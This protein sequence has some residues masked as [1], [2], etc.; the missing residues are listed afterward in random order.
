MSSQNSRRSFLTL[1]TT[2][3]ALA[4]CR[5]QA[6]LAPERAQPVPA[7]AASATPSEKAAVAADGDALDVSAVEDLMREHGVIRR[8]LVVYRESAIRLRQ[9]P[10]A[11]LAEA[12]QSS[13]KL[14]QTFGEEYHERALEEA[15]LFPAVKRAGGPA[16]NSIDALLAQ[17][18]RGRELTSYVLTVTQ[19]PL[20]V[21][22]AEPLARVLEGF[23]RMYEEHAAH[24]DT[25]VFQAWKK[26]LSGK[27]L[28]EMG[29]LFEDIEHKTFGKDGFEAANA[30]IAGIEASLGITLSGLLAPPP[31]V[32]H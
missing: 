2:G 20:S 16:S 21:A 1:A 10:S 11:L 27:Q 8:I 29:E 18:Q 14:M 9:K 19:R 13:A 17:H 6:Q 22:S 32:A 31:P 15:Q 12:L 28:D 24:E 7:S 30:K 4:A 3:V 5:E 26:S 25:V 23:A